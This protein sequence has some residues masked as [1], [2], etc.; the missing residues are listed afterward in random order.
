MLPTAAYRYIWVTCVRTLLLARS[1]TS[2]LVCKGRV[3]PHL[4]TLL[5][6]LFVSSVLHSKQ[7]PP[8]NSNCKLR[9]SF[10]SLCT[11]SH[12]VQCAGGQESYLQGMVVTRTRTSPAR[13]K[14]HNQA[15]LLKL[16]VQSRQNSPCWVVS[17]LKASL[18]CT[19]RQSRWI[20]HTVT[21]KK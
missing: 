20:T 2:V 17:L 16:G 6:V 12:G 1:V 19:M 5:S 7:E 15:T 3:I 18:T 9:A 21:S 4:Y 14:F 11:E 8:D 10:A 13:G